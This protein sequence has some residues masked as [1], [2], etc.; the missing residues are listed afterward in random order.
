MSRLNRAQPGSRHCK[1]CSEG[2]LTGAQARGCNGVRRSTY[3]LAPICI[4]QG[5]IGIGT[6]D[7]LHWVVT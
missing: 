3:S 7:G 2:M 5:Q 1:P 6:L 4:G